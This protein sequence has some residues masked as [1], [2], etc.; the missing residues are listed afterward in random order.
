[1]HTVHAYRR[2]RASRPR[3]QHCTQGAEAQD[4]EWPPDCWADFGQ[5][6]G[7]NTLP[8]A[9]LTPTRFGELF[10]QW[11]NDTPAC[12]TIALKPAVSR[13]GQRASPPAF[14]LTAL[15]LRVIQ[16][17]PCACRTQTPVTVLLEPGPHSLFFRYVNSL[18]FLGLIRGPPQFMNISFIQMGSA[19][20]P[21][22]STL[23]QVATYR[24]PFPSAVGAPTSGP[25][26][27]AISRDANGLLATGTTMKLGALFA[28]V[29]ENANAS[30]NSPRGP[31]HPR[32][33]LLLFYR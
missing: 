7:A 11:L 22:P 6:T 26:I 28:N 32:T 10:R 2:R 9:E 5:V 33:H 12:L 18:P 24:A 8:L 16:M 23:Q 30:T 13:G 20:Y 25:L 4:C 14:L 17:G 31:L 21:A 3:T 1:M 29:P 19:A 15:G 27:H